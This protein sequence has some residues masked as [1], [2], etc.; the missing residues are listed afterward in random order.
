MWPIF[1]FG[2]SSHPHPT[3]CLLHRRKWTWRH[4]FL[5]NFAGFLWLYNKKPFTVNYSWPDENFIILGLWG[6]HLVVVNAM[7]FLHYF[8]EGIYKYT[9]DKVKSE[10]RRRREFYYLL[11][12]LFPDRVVGEKDGKVYKR[13]TG[14]I[15]INFIS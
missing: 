12:F 1:L 9:V 3:I 15:W 14:G 4:H 8:F 13:N 7:A 5:I 2:W 6:A 10:I 11:K